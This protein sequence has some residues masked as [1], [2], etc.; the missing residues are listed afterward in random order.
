MP[1]LAKDFDLNVESAIMIEA[2]TGQILYKK[3]PDK[4]VPP[5]SITKIMTLLIAMEQ[6]EKGKLN[7]E[8][9]VSVSK[10]AESMGGSQIYLPSNTRIKA[11]N[12]LKAVTIA[13]ANDASVAIAEAIAGT[14]GNFIAMMNEKAEKMGLENTH[15]V[16]STGLPEEGNNHFST[17]RD[18]ALMARQL[19]K[20]EKIREWASTWVDYVPL[21]DRRAMLV[22]TNKL[23]KK[24]PGMD[25]LKTGHTSEAGFCLAATAK[26]NDMRLISVILDAN[27]ESTREEITTRLLDYGFNGFKKEIVI[28]K[29]KIVNNIEVPG[30]KKTVT[31]A[32]AAVNL[33][34]I[35]QRGSED[36]IEI[37]T[38]LNDN[39]KAPINE[40]DVLGKNIIAFKGD[41]IGEV[42][43]IATE[44]IEKANIFVRLW[45]SFVNWIGS[46]MKNI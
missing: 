41:K 19:V 12:L 21:P 24:Y 2:E 8:D 32:K 46:W 4:K 7:L 25:G 28:K 35:I 3:K 26:R 23:I 31:T 42:K 13:S 20:Y 27:S 38:I 16:N 18:I 17:A 37:K 5:A 9:E 10:Y 44:K 6:I 11:K 29:G 15:F 34:V 40:G 39:I 36:D 43:L 22:N 33:P 30:G 1:I 14:Y 45:R